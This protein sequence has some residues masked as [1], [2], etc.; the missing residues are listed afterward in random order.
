MTGNPEHDAARLLPPLGS[1]PRHDDFTLVRRSVEMVCILAAV[2]LLIWQL[3]RLAVVSD[4]LVWWMPLAAFAGA[5]AADFV[6]GLI[7]WT[8][9]TWG[10]EKM[11]V[12]GRRFVRPF[13][14]HHINPGDFLRRG[15]LDTNGD[16][17]GIVAGSLAAGFLL[18]LDAAWGNAAMTFLLAFCA[19]GLPTNQV[20]QWAHSP[21]PPW[22]V[23]RFQQFGL[24]LSRPDHLRHHR[25]PYAANYCIATGWLN[26]PLEAANFFRRLERLVTQVA[27]LTPRADDFAFQEQ[28]EVEFVAGPHTAE[29]RP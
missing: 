11:P 29:D 3:W 18:P 28:F 20:H 15:F 25:E 8:A 14:V 27:G 2:S 9:D 23:R 1:L 12:L 13:R 7:H 24:I 22:L 16:V 6:S 4:R 10:S 5:A 26:R 19:A 17:A 21:R